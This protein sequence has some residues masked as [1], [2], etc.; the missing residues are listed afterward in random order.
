MEIG[1]RDSEAKESKSNALNNA[2]ITKVCDQ[3]LAQRGI[4]SAPKGKTLETPVGQRMRITKTNGKQRSANEKPADMKKLI[5]K[6]RVL[7]G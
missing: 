2:E 1:V 7:R 5:C 6:P 4:A 3:W